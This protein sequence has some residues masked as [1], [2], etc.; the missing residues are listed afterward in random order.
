MTSLDSSIAEII[1]ASCV[2]HANFSVTYDG[3]ASSSLLDG[4]YVIIKK[5]DSIQIH[6]SKHINPINYQTK[7][8]SYIK[9]DNVLVCT[10]KKEV[11]K[12]S[13]N[14]IYSV[15][16]LDRWDD[17]ALQMRRTEK[18]FVQNICANINEI[19]QD[20][21]TSV[22]VEHKTDVGPIDIVARG[23][24]LHIIEVKRKTANISAFSQALRYYT[25]F[26]NWSAPE[27][28]VRQ[29]VQCWIIAPGISKSCLTNCEK[30]GIK[31]HRYS[32]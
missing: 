18:E 3:R 31:Y 12:L 23:S 15:I 4:D 16:P 32:Y 22:E 2:V 29:E 14:Q 5:P 25:F 1:E 21:I 19:C 28:T 11:L 17:N 30:N 24:K 8:V 27:G 13:F 26:K 9:N 7:S 10:S 20:T 6:T